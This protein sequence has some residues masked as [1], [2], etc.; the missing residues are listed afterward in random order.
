MPTHTHKHTHRHTHTWP[1]YLANKAR[2][3]SQKQQKHQ[4]LQELAS[5]HISQQKD[6]TLPFLSP[7][8]EGGLSVC[9]I[10]RMLSSAPW[11]SSLPLMQDPPLFNQVKVKVTQS[12]PTLC[13]LSNYSPSGSSVHRILQGRILEWIAMPFSRGS[14]QPIERTWVSC[15]AG[16]F[17]TVWGAREALFHKRTIQTLL[18]GTSEML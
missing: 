10:L 9:I 17:F 12:C 13:D 4:H 3:G 5:H 7:P 6:M 8:L 2:T 11:W 14:S 1:S 16:K 18:E 15:I